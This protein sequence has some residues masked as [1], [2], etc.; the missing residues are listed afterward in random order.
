MRLTD[1]RIVIDDNP[2]PARGRYRIRRLV[3]DQL[4]AILHARDEGELA[5][6]VATE[7]RMRQEEIDAVRRAAARAAEKP[8]V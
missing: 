3:D 8:A 1:W 4:V 2:D 6:L 5:S 7:A